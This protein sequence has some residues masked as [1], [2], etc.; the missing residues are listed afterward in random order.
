MKLHEAIGTPLRL[1]SGKYGG[2]VATVE[3]LRELPLGLRGFVRSL[4]GRTTPNNFAHAIID[5]CLVDVMHTGELLEEVRRG[6]LRIDFR[7]AHRPERATGSRPKRGGFAASPRQFVTFC[8]DPWQTSALRRRRFNLG[9]RFWRLILVDEKCDQ[10]CRSERNCAQQRP[11][12]SQ[13]PSPHGIEM[14]HGE[15]GA[16]LRRARSMAHLQSGLSAG[17]CGA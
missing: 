3:K 16:L 1:A 14:L 2:T 17:W 9:G 6:E 7:V 11:Q 15:C 13:T 5:R 12:N 8:F 4:R 10:R